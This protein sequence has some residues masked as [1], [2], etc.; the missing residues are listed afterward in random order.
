MRPVSSS[1]LCAAPLR[2]ILVATAVL[3]AASAPARALAPADE[4]GRVDADAVWSPPQDFLPRF[5]KACD[6]LAGPK[7]TECFVGQMEKEGAPPA[8]LAFARRIGGDGYLR[9]F[10]DTG[11]V[12][13][14]YAAIPFRANENSVCLL[15][16]GEPALIDVDDLSRLDRATLARNP[17]YARILRRQPKAAIFPADRYATDHPT[18]SAGAD[19][20]TVFRVSYRVTTGCHACETVG[21]LDLDFAFDSGGRFLGIRV[22]A[23]RPQSP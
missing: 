19:G 15:V 8:A 1:A 18:V 17:D 16:N 20:G 13:V 5:H 21:T 3:G 11:R 10:R 6:G 7:F 9:A 2:A 12:D 22:A 4:S 23:V 14:A